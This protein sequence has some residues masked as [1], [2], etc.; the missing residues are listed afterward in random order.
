MTISAEESIKDRKILQH[1]SFLNLSRGS[2][3]HTKILIMFA[4][5]AIQTFAYVLIGN[6]IFEIKGMLLPYWIILFTTACF[7]NVLGLN[8]SS[9]LNSVITIYIMIPFLVIPMILFCGVLVKYDKLHHSLTNYEYVPLIGNLMPSRWSYEA[10]A[11]EQFKNNEYEKIFFYTDQLKNDGDYM[12]SWLV[13]KM[14]ARLTELKESYLDGEDPEII[15]TE[16]GILN[17]QLAEI[18]KLVPQLQPYQPPEGT[19]EILSDS[20][21]QAIQSY[22]E[23]VQQLTRNIKLYA[24]NEWNHINDSLHEELGTKAYQDFKNMYHNDNLTDLVLNRNVATKVDE[25]NGRMIRKHTPAY[26]K[27]TSITGKAHLYAPIKRLGKYEIETM[28]YNIVVIWLYTLILYVTLR[29]DLL[30]KLIN[31]SETRRLRRLSRRQAT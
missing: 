16:L 27:P 1:E 4:I 23:N 10:L 29:T 8:L 2:Y 9:G 17:N 20:T 22:L 15:K 5:S 25:K 31:I 12:S 6:F 28:W 26:M 3:L 30:Q 13:P 21:V 18:G 7:G 14:E 19:M 24:Q 11:V